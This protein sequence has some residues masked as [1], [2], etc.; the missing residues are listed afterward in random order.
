MLEYFSQNDYIRRSKMGFQ[1]V[2]LTKNGL[3]YGTQ[4]FRQYVNDNLY[5]SAAFLHLSKAFDSILH[6]ILLDKLQYEFHFS[7]H[8]KSVIDDYLSDNLY[9]K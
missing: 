7:G 9:K 3:N 8:S 4:I 6:E 1:K 2:I 5:V